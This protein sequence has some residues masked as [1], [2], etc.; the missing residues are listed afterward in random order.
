M[1]VSDILQGALSV[2]GVKKYAGTNGIG[3]KYVAILAAANMDFDRLRF[4]SE[5]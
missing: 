4:I 1:F 2:A 5:R 3:K